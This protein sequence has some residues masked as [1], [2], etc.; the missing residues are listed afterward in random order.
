MKKENFQTYAD[1]K[2]KIKE[3]S[4]QAEI[5]EGE[6]LQEITEAG[7]EKVESGFGTF[8]L[9]KRKTWKYSED[10]KTLEE[11]MKKNKKMEEENGTATFEE[12]TSLRFQAT[13][14]SLPV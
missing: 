1:L 13:K 11:G 4:Q 8:S 7:V 5:I 6:I 3:L 14:E 10:I 2:N 9:M 12:K